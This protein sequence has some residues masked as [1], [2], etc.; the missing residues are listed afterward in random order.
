MYAQSNMNAAAPFNITSTTKILI[1]IIVA[2]LTIIIVLGGWSWN[3]LQKVGPPANVG[4]QPA[5]NL[6]A[7]QAP[8]VVLSVTLSPSGFTPVEISQSAGRFNLKVTNHSEQQE[9]VLRLKK[10]GG[11]QLSEVRV[12]EKVNSWTGQFDL[13]PGVYNLSEASHPG[14]TYQI[15][16]TAP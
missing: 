10:V 13:A 6:N 12:S 11:E 16:L 4:S 9:I 3:M 7:N 8:P 1:A 2:L 5:L 14:W 15:T